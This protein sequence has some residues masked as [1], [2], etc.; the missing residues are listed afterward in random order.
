[1]SDH[2]ARPSRAA[3]WLLRAASSPHAAAALLG[4]LLEELDERE[5]AGRAPRWTTLWLDCQILQSVFV[6]AWI[7][8]ARLVRMCRYALRDA[9]RALRRSP[10]HAVF[11][12]VILSVGIAAVTVTFSVVDAVVLKPLP[13]E[14]GD[15]IVML[16]GRNL[17][18]Q[19]SLA[20]EEFWAIHDG[21]TGLESVASA[22]FWKTPVDFGNG[23]EELSVMYSTSELF[24]VLRLGPLLGQLW[25][26]EGEQ[27]SDDNVA[28]IS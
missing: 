10:A 14:Q 13:F 2:L 24:R 27:R 12:L 15:A 18:G 11:I 17:R 26:A 1:M 5:A 21:V 7:A 19:T 20:P 23:T 22:R 8:A 25:T 4:D 16:S 3:V 28:A 9:A 6:F